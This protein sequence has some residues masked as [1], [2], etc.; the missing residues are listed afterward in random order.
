MADRI[1]GLSGPQE[2]DITLRRTAVLWRAF[3]WRSLVVGSD[4]GLAIGAV[5]GGIVGL[6]NGS[7]QTARSIGSAMGI[8]GG[9]L[10][11]FVAIRVVLKKRF[12]EF[13]VALIKNDQA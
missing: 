10:G 9:I 5:V 12:S 4:C 13:R 3:F 11:S 2:L 1:A 6:F 8:V 7:T